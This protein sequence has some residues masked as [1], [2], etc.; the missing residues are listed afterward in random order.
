MLFAVTMQ[1]NL[2]PDL[3]PAV[4]ADLLAREAAYSRSQQEAGRW[5]HLWRIAGQYANL[6][7]IDA[8]DNAQL[9]DI[10]SSLPLFPY[11]TIDV[12][13]LTRHPNSIRD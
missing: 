6:S 11:M 3:D 12:R 1:V 2:P 10:L 8:Q 9:H 13:P 4:R 5:P 7:V